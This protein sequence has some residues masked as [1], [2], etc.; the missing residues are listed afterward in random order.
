MHI[1]GVIILTKAEGVIPLNQQQFTIGEHRMIFF[2][3]NIMKTLSDTDF[4]KSLEKLG[5]ILQKRQMSG[6]PELF[7]ED[8]SRELR[9]MAV[10]VNTD[11]RTAIITRCK[12][13]FK[14]MIQ[15]NPAHDCTESL[16]EVAQMIAKI[17]IGINTLEDPH[18]SMDLRFQL[19]AVALARILEEKSESIFKILDARCVLN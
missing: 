4:A 7:F 9:L 3:R 12:T 5:A 11:N 8:S 18:E 10:Q 15:A 14:H 19:A 16:E 17:C 2:E 1:N 13:I 6:M